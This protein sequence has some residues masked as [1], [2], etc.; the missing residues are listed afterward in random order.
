MTNLRW[1]KW[2]ITKHYHNQHLQVH[3]RTIKLGNTA[4]D[5]EVTST[6]W[7]M[8]IEIK[9]PHD[10]VTRGL[11]QLAEAL[12]YGYDKAALITTLQHA[13]KIKTKIF[14]HLNL[15]LIGIDSKGI[16]HQLYPETFE[17]S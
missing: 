3:L 15:T 2:H 4:I 9:T 10:D 7:R 14:H 13:R 17:Q 11:G 16:L 8:A 6:D 5:G 12:A 1:L